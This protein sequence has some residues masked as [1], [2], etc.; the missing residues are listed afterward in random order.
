M[1]ARLDYYNAEEMQKIIL[2]SARLL[3]VEIDPAGAI[4]L[5][6][7]DRLLVARGELFGFIGKSE[8]QMK[9]SSIRWMGRS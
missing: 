4:D 1:S 6:G 2:R 5:P 7:A 3:G 9:C 8:L